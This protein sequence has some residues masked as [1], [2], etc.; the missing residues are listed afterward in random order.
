MD[1]S[2]LLKRGNGVVMGGKN[3]KRGRAETEVKVIKRLPV[4]R[5]HPI[6]RHQPQTLMWMARMA[7]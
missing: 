5:I 3:E 4:L 7:C 2:V 6:Y 1:A